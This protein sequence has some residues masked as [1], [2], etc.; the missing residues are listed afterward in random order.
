MTR[1]LYRLSIRCRGLVALRVARLRHRLGA[2]LYKAGEW[3]GW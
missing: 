1:I 3:R 2:L